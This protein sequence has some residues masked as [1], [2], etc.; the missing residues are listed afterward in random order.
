M[1]PS[2]TCSGERWLPVAGV[3]RKKFALMSAH[4][5]EATG[6]QRSPEQVAEGFIHIAVA[7]MANAIKQISVQRGHDV[8]EYTLCCFGGA[9]GQHACL[10]ADALGMTRVFIHPLAGVLS[11]YGMGL[12]DLTVMREQTMELPL[13]QESLPLVAERL[14][15]LGAAAQAELERQQV[16]AGKVHIHH[17][18]H[19]RYEGSD[20]ALV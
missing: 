5:R 17:R 4:I 2:A 3:V 12:A 7:N 9:A 20:S 15:A 16:N 11:A 14:D 18:V 19:V 8:T 10:V 6:N 13:A 1:K